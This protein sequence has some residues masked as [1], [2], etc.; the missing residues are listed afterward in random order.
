M[1]DNRTTSAGYRFP[2]RS[3]PSE[4][5]QTCVPTGRKA[6]PAAGGGGAAAGRSDGGAAQHDVVTQDEVWKQ[7]VGK[8]RA[9]VKEWYVG[10]YFIH[11][12]NS[13]EENQEQNIS[14][15]GLY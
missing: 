3:R 10:V 11:Y 5:H 2:L 4:F 15:V 1:G 9:G 12:F 6:V 7:S 13:M 8:E 14:T